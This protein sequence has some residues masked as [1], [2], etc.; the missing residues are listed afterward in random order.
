M[1]RIKLLIDTDVFI[2]YLNTG[3]LHAL[4]ENRDVEIYYSVVTKKELLCKGGLKEMERRAIM[5]TLKRYR[6][7]PLD[8][9]ITS[10]Y[11][12]LRIRQPALEKEDALIAAAALARKL[13]LVTRNQRHYKDIEG[14]ILFKNP[15]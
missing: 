13:P 10:I 3:R 5:H 8:D 12:E 7:I 6:I 14:L 9:R 1:A 11:S 2:D 4:F 15:R